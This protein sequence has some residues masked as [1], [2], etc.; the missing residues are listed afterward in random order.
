MKRR[1]IHIDEEKCTGCGLCVHACHEG[2]IGLVGGKARL[3]RDD[4][5]DGLGDCLPACPENAIEF[6]EREAAAYDEAAVIAEKMRRAQ[7]EIHASM[8]AGGCPGSMAKTIAREAEPGA[9]SES[10]QAAP[11]HGVNSASNASS[12]ENP[13]PAPA[14]GVSTV[15]N[16]PARLSN[17]PVQIKLAPVNAPYF[18]GCD[19]LV[20]AD[21]TAF[22]YGAFHEDFLKGRVCLIGCPK[23][24]GVDYTE[25]L[26]QII[27]EN[28]V[29]SVRVARMQVPCCGGL[30]QAVRRAVAIAGSQNSA[31]AGG[32]V[33][34]A[35]GAAIGAGGADITGG[36]VDAVGAVAS[37]IPVQIDVISSDG[38]IVAVG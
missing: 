22:A 20:A 14:G 4:Y 9:V 13:F 10:G 31:G 6:I 1:V 8:P 16:V 2:A 28:N 12:S 29:R 15:V 19:L 26:A 24:D 33:V 23:L 11:A 7:A 37:S 18:Q 5:C 38:R 36:A 30:E 27:A 21:C 3:L 35:R 17:W 32:A 34:G 25:K